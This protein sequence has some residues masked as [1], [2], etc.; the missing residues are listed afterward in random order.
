M[1][2][3]TLSNVELE[4]WLYA[5][6]NDLAAREEMLKRTCSV[7]YADDDLTEAEDQITSLESELEDAQAEVRRGEER[8]AESNQEVDNLRKQITDAGIDLL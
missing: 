6:P 3:S 4:R 1:N 2:F 5:S 8:L 7:Q